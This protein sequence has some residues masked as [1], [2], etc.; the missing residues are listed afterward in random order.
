LLTY[1]SSLLPQLSVTPQS[2]CHHQSLLSLTALS[3]TTYQYLLPLEVKTSVH[4][5]GV[6]DIVQTE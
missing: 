3:M 4:P 6:I 5:E 2:I 1:P